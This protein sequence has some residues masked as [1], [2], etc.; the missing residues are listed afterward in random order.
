[1]GGA[2]IKVKLAGLFGVKDLYALFAIPFTTGLKKA[3]R[4]HIEEMLQVILQTWLKDKSKIVQDLFEK[5]ITGGI[6]RCAHQHIA[7][8]DHLINNI[9]DSLLT[10]TEG[11]AKK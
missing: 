8:A 11:D 7:D 1:V 2:G 9:N 3:D 6:I 4:Q 10:C 5:N